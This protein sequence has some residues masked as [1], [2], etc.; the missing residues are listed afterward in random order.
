MLSIK[1]VTKF[2]PFLLAAAIM[3]PAQDASAQTRRK[4][5]ASAQ[6]A[7]KKKSAPAKKNVTKSASKSGK[8]SSA[9][10]KKAAK[11]ESS[12]QLKKRQ[13][14]TQ[15]EIKLTEEQIRRNEA[16]VKKNLGELNRLSADVAV[17]RKQVAAL[18]T[19]VDRLDNQIAELDSS[20]ATNEKELTRLR[21][22]YLSAVRKM[23]AK[24][25]KDS[26]L[27]FVFAADNFNQ[28]L[29]RMRYLRQFGDW[30]GKQSKEISGKVDQLKREAALLAQTKTEKD[31]AL[32]Q[33]LTTERK[34]AEQHSRQDA[35][36]VELRRNGDALRSHLKRK[37]Q[38]AN[39]LKGSIASAIAA[40]ERKAAEARRAEEA[41]LQAQKDAAAKKAAEDA[42]KAEEA[43]K[44][45][46]ELADNTPAKQE[47]PKKEVTKKNTKKT[48]TKSSGKDYADARGRKPRE[49]AAE[50]VKPSAPAKSETPKLT[51][52]FGNFEAARG[53]LPRPVNG[54][55]RVTSQFGRHPLPDL[56]D[57]MY[58]NPGID[59]E[60]SAGASAQAI[61]N[62]R[63]TGVY[64]I[65]GYN[66]V[67]IVNHGNYYTVYGNLLASN[68]K[69]DDNVKTGQ[70]IGRV[71]DD[72][73]GGYPSIH[74][75]VWKNR[76][77]LN[78]LDWIR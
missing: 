14:A 50:P 30:R 52:S 59:A 17:S 6:T 68:V 31:H 36:V 3:I 4:K 57:I 56:P 76:D 41:R 46:Q 58:D 51:A 53:S 66:T 62:G 54:P 13:Q 61:F 37:Q 7:Q 78:P 77:K 29:R 70:A 16:E 44:A 28:S 39:D 1:I 27:A 48:E 67:V 9:T 43:S 75:E 33:Q 72:D 22:N 10:A 64:K 18:K 32:A 12:E 35:I 69:V 45:S 55:F 20:I 25:G 40:E 42:R 24:K 65:P 73:D 49:K 5:A 15:K 19:Q 63:V 8:S 47:A 74:F 26:S 60:V 34:L 71:A 2:L 11:P 23:R 38:E 21:E